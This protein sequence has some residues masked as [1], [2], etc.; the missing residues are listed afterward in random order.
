MDVNRLKVLFE[1][2]VL[3]K[4]FGSECDEVTGERRRLHN[5]KLYDL[6]SSPI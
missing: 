1:N 3:W 4:I 6:F 2:R 5:E